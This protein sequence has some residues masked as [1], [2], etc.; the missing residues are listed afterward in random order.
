MSKNIQEIEN[1]YGKEMEKD[2]YN[3]G[4]RLIELRNIIRSKEKLVK[5]DAQSNISDSDY[6][7]TNFN[8]NPWTAFSKY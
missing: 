7:W 3:F 2:E 1:K 8:D 4:D 5:N 6:Q